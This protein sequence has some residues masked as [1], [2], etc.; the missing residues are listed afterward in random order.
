LQFIQKNSTGVSLGKPYINM[1]VDTYSNDYIK[2]I[3]DTK[4]GKGAS[5][6]IVGAF[7]YYSENSTPENN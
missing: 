1:L 3:T 2:G 4:Y 7:R 5:D 6:Y